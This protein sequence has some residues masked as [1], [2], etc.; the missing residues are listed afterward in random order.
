MAANA[1]DAASVALLLA[2]KK[3]TSD[4]VDAHDKTGWTALHVAASAGQLVCSAARA[5]A[6]RSPS[7][8]LVQMVCEALLDAGAQVNAVDTKRTTPLHYAGSR[9]LFFGVGGG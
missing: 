4:F 2:L 7:I 6:P 1:G 5:R 8:A 3:R 9:C